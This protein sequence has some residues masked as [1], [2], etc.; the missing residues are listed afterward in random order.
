[1]ERF[2]IRFIKEKPD[3]GIHAPIYLSPEVL[4]FPQSTISSILNE[5][6]DLYKTS[7]FEIV[8][9]AINIHR[10]DILSDKKLRVIV[11]KSHEDLETDVDQLYRDKVKSIYGEIIRYASTAQSTLILNK[12]Q[13][14]ILTDLKVANRKMVEIVKSSSELNR[15]INLVLQSDNQD[16]KKEYDAFRRKLIKVLRI[17]YLFRTEEGGTSEKYIAQLASLRKEAKENKRQSNKA[18]D[19]LIRKNLI[20][21]EMASSLFNDYSNVNDMIKKLIEVAELL[22]EQK[23]SLLENEN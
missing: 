19:E 13:N 7:V 21:A 1:M 3:K 2:L 18:I 17:I 15:N 11:E 20:S 16:L 6:Q 4:E 10:E 12:D 8:A 23:D 14:K 9:H 22:Y 5:S